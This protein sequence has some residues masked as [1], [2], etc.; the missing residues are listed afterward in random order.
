MVNIVEL[1]GRPDDP[2]AEVDV[3][4]VADDRQP[5]QYCNRLFNPVSYAKHQNKCASVFMGLRDKR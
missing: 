5:C 2:N 4:T 3:M 1:V